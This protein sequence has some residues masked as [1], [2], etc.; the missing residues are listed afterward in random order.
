[1]PALRPRREAFVRNVFQS[2][3]TG[4]S[5]AACYEAAGYKTTGHSSETNASRMLKDAE[6]KMRLNEMAQPAVRRAQVSIEAL[7]NELDRT[8]AD[9]R[10]DRAHGAVVA[11]IALITKIAA[12]L[13]ERVDHDNEFAG[14]T[15]DEIMAMMVNEFGP[16]GLEELADDLKA[17]AL[18]AA[19]DRA[20]PV[21]SKP[22]KRQ[23]RQSRYLSAT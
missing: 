16:E 9:A 15:S 18:R 2:P 10:A 20:K 17:N 3:K 12:M 22:K 19:S 11:A 21:E 13:H 4:W 23:K 1:M 6:V 8:I 5:Q 7:L 14:K